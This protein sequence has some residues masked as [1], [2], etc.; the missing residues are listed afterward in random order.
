MTATERTAPRVLAQHEQSCARCRFVAEHGVVHQGLCPIGDGLRRIIESRYE[1]GSPLQN[2]DVLH[3]VQ[4]LAEQ[5]G[6]R[7][8]ER[9][10]AIHAIVNEYMARQ[11]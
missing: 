11:A 4:L 2:H 8:R 3:V 10:L 9:L 7:T 5:S 6:V 1:I